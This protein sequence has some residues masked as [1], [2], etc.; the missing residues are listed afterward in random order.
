MKCITCEA[1]LVEID[2]FD[3]CLSCNRLDKNGWIN[4]LVFST[5]RKM[6]CH[7]F[8]MPEVAIRFMEARNIT[9]EEVKAAI[10]KHNWRHDAPLRTLQVKE[11]R[12]IDLLKANGL[13]VERIESGGSRHGFYVCKPEEVAGNKVPGQRPVKWRS[14][15]TDALIAL[16]HPNREEWVLHVE[17][18]WASW[19]PGPQAGPFYICNNHASLANAV[20]DVLD[21]YFGDPNRMDLSSFHCNNE[22]GSK[23]QPD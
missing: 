6:A 11:Q 1:E 2:S 20:T 17:C 21:Y 22:A 8:V 4:Q 12:Q 10:D 14:L 7:H 19:A 18:P 23:C 15:Q 3:L 13:V 5:L 9:I 16:L